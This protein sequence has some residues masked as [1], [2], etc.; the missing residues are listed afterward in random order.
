MSG[1]VGLKTVMNRLEG[2]CDK[3]CQAKDCSSVTYIPKKL[4]FQEDPD[5][6]LVANLVPQSPTIRAACQAA[7]TP[8]QYL[9]DVASIFGFWSGVSAFGFFDFVKE[10]IKHVDDAYLPKKKKKNITRRITQD[11][12]SPPP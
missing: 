9:T 4:S 1:N 10:T 2:I 12:L 7:V 5:V 3:R 8:I 11:K 6:S